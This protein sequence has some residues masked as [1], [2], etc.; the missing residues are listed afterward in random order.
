VR[1]YTDEA[2]SAMSDKRPAF[3]RM[4]EDAKAGLFC[5]V[6]VHEL[7]RFSR[8]KYDSVHYKRALRQCG[9]KLESV[10]EPLDNSPESVILESLLEGHAK[11]NRSIPYPASCTARPAARRW[12]ALRSKKAAILMWGMCAPTKKRKRRTATRPASRLNP[13]RAR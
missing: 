9:V 13:S 5:V 11:Q 7:D 10:L 2:K 1:E 8:D 6:I 4:I 3:Q 12:S